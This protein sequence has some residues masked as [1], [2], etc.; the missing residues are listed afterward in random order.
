VWVLEEEANVICSI[1]KKHFKVYSVCCK[2]CGISK[3]DFELEKIDKERRESMCNPIG[4]AQ[5]SMKKTL[6]LIL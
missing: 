5:S 2:V 3:E 6:I 1:F 4:Q